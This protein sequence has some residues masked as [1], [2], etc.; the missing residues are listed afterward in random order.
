MK[1]F[2]LEIENGFYMIADGLRWEA[3]DLVPTIKRGVDWPDSLLN[4]H[5]GNIL[6]LYQFASCRREQGQQYQGTPSCH[7]VGVRV[8]LGILF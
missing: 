8:C 3:N 7:I 1:I 5:I 4:A 2:F 6:Y